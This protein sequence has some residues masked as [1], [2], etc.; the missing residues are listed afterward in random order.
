MT[1]KQGTFHWGHEALH[2]ALVLDDDGGPRLTHLGLPGEAARRVPGASLPPF[3]EVTAA[4]HGRDWSGS[5]LIGTALGGRLRHRTHRAARDGDRHTLTVHLHDPETRLVA[6][7]RAD[8]AW[9]PDT[10]GL[11]P[12]LPTAPSAVLLRITPTDPGAP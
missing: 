12:T 7:S 4:G 6:V 10:A 9:L 2:L 5:R 3:V 1:E 8:C 11:S